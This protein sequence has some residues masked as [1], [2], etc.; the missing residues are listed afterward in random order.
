MN[1]FAPYKT[2]ENPAEKPKAVIFADLKQRRGMLA[3]VPPTRVGARKP[4]TSAIPYERL[5]IEKTEI[6]KIRLT[7]SP[8]CE[9]GR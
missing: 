9:N 6:L 1:D 5:T 7:L 8:S 4:D 2:S 3:A